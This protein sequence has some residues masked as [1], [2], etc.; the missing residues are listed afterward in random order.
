MGSGIALTAL[1]EALPVII[2]DI[3]P[4]VLESAQAYV[5]KYLAK[6]GLQAYRN[7][8]QITT[9]IEDLAKAEFVIEAVPEDL[10]L[11]QGLISKLDAICPPSTILATNTS[12]L[13]VSAIAAA[14]QS[15]GRV[16][17][18]QRRYFCA[19]RNREKIEYVFGV[20]ACL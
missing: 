5:E 7:Q 8:L 11:K 1:Y 13:S 19:K 6:K 12:T 9:S 4:S 18:K 16:S 20:S 15:P 14:T 2:Y 17:R 10:A 3:S